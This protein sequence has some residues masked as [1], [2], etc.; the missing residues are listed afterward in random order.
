MAA[1]DEW[2]VFHYEW[3]M[4]RNLVR[5]TKERWDS[6]NLWCRHA[7][8]ESLVLQTRILADIFLP[9]PKSK[10][11]DIKITDL[12][13]GFSSPHT[14]SLA[15]AYGD[16]KTVGCPCWQ[17]NKLLAHA[18]RH[19]GNSHQYGPALAEMWPHIERIIE[20]IKRTNPPVALD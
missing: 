2:Q 15:A 9:T 1:G 16:S 13:P 17:F 6:L 19:R 12:I 5:R 3:A 18:T 20:D 14:A 11:D 8:V 4:V 10:P 7:I